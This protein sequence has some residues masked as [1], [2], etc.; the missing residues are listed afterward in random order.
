[1]WPYRYDAADPCLGANQC[2]SN[3]GGAQ[4]WAC[5]SGEAPYTG[6][7]MGSIHPRVKKVVGMRLAQAARAI[8]YG[9]SD[10]L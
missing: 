9:D 1:M 5:M 3:K 10:M 8:A 6:Q 2:C 7:F 4:G